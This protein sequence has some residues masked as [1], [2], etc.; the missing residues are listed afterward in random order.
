[1]RAIRKVRPRRAARADRG[2]RQDL[3][4]ACARRSG[5]ARER[6]PLAELR[7]SV[8][9][10]RPDSFLVA[11]SAGMPVSREADLDL[12][13]EADAAPDIIGINHYLTSERYLD[14]RVEP[15]SRSISSEATD[16]NAM[17]TS[18]PCGCGSRRDPSGRRHVC[19]RPGTAIAGRLRSPRCITAAREKNRCAGCPRSG[20]RPRL[21]AARGGEIRAVTVWALFGAVDWNSLL[22]RRIAVYE[23][24]PSMSAVRRRGRPRWPRCEGACTT[25]PLRS[26]GS[27]PGRLVEARGAVL[28]AY[29]A[30]RNAD[31]G[32]PDGA[33]PVIVGVTG[34]LGAALTRICHARGS[35][36]WPR[37]ETTRRAC[38]MRCGPGPSSTPGPA[39][40]ELQA[41]LPSPRLLRSL[42]SSSPPTACSTH[43]IRAGENPVAPSDVVG[44]TIALRKVRCR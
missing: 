32:W 21:S 33:P 34:P 41:S 13:L 23:P 19:G 6:A 8:R 42:F 11:D 28:P 5:G 22:T 20:G 44:R 27:R 36:T 18:R 2:S 43:A 1:M 40:A 39:G 26:S 30:A 37:R 4:D 17:L 38:S 9:P 35:T 12:F 24:G 3:L 25:G 15:L 31:F 14:E 16:A 29:C 10:G 7:S